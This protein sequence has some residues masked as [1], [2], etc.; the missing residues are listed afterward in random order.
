MKLEQ[1]KG[2]AVAGIAMCAL[3]LGILGSNP[4]NAAHRGST[5]IPATYNDVTAALLPLS[6]LFLKTFKKTRP[7][8]KGYE[9]PPWNIWTDYKNVKHLSIM[10]PAKVRGDRS[11]RGKAYYDFDGLYRGRVK[12]KNLVEF[13][14]SKGAEAH[15]YFNRGLAISFGSTRHPGPFGIV[16]PRLWA[17]WGWVPGHGARTF[18][19]CSKEG[20]RRYHPGLSTQILSTGVSEA[21]KVL[22]RARKHRPLARQKDIFAGM[23]PAEGCPP[24]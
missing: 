22:R 2:G 15:R 14:L 12:P 1:I 10:I 11:P 24:D 13:R 4:A 16:V 3:V 19:S 5:P 7:A 23:K 18:D 6:K 9:K 8:N 20:K 21:M 17:F